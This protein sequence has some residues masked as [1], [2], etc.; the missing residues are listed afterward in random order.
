MAGRA[1][2]AESTRLQGA[3][4]DKFLDTIAVD[5]LGAVGQ[6]VE[7]A[8]TPWPDLVEAQLVEERWFATY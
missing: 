7:E 4:R 2:W 8:A 6:T 5:R 3:D 1:I